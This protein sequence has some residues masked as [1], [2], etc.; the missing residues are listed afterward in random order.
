MLK[1]TL[2][3]GA[4]R[5]S[6]GVFLRTLA[7]ISGVEVLVMGILVTFHDRA[8]NIDAAS[9]I[10]TA[11]VDAGMLSLL[12]A[13]L[14]YA[15]VVR[16][17]AQRLS[18]Q[19][20]LDLVDGLD[21]IVWEADAATWEFSLVSQ[22][23]EEILGYPLKLW[24][25]K[26]DFWGSVI[27][28]EDRERVTAL[29][30][31]AASQGG[32]S[33]LEYRIMTSEGRVLWFRNVV[34]AV[35]DGEGRVRRLRGLMV[36]ITQQKQAEE[37][38]RDTSEKMRTLIEAIPDAVYFKD[39]EGRWLL[40]NSA[41]L[42]AF[43]LEGVS[44]EGK[45]DVEVAEIRPGYRD[46]LLACT[47]TDEQAWKH[48]NASVHEEVI[49]RPDGP[50]VFET[51]KV[52][53]FNHDGSRKGL[54]IVGRDITER[55]L[56]QA[57]LV[58]LADRDPLTGLFNRRRFQ[59]ELEREVAQARRYGSHGAVMF[60]D[61]DDFKDINDSFGHLEGDKL[62]K[63][64]ANLLRKRLRVTDV[65]AR[66]GGD[67][68]A[69][70]LSHTGTRQAQEVADQILEGVGRHTS[71]LGGKSVRITASIGI[72]LYPEHG[73][74]VNELLA[75]ADVAMYRVKED[76]GN[77]AWVYVPDPGTQA[78]TESRL[79]W[80]ARIR[81]AL[82]KDLFVLHAQ[83]IL[84]LRSNRISHHELLLRMV[85]DGGEVIP[86][87]SFLGVAERFGLVHQIDRWVVRRAIGIIADHRRAGQDLCLAV[88]LSGKAFA[89]REL[90]NLIRRQLE[91]NAIDPTRLVLEITE[92]AAV[93]DINQ[94]RQFVDLLRGLGCR[95]ALDDFGVGFSS[96]YN[97]KHL[98]VDYLKIDGSFIRDLPR[99][100]V[101]EHVVKA[102]VEVARGMGKQTVA[103]FVEDEETLRLLR[104]YG[105]DYAQGYHIGRPRALY[106]N[107]SK[108]LVDQEQWNPS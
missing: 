14:L 7:V 102:M 84:D 83:P 104:E 54:V 59:E 73:T 41:G 30:W 67:E 78:Q 35:R 68:F 18:L 62:L 45:S 69:I 57:R 39:G 107:A 33:E 80:K 13:P 64:L 55:K 53:L 105:V 101:D 77:G 46:A 20:A 71:L 29:L 60:L 27:H 11:I 28:P 85:G 37:S 5:T 47:R 94:A 56:V 10:W 6:L 51:I 12:S 26:P 95:F 21:A 31:A 43:E 75:H 48:K 24:L 87:G 65:I 76:G 97:L 92:T 70:L 22:R 103:E 9:D 61:L 89:D 106:G 23:A 19:G 36:D 66:L 82:D 88:N 49:S 32:D 108:I 3:K 34:R 42:R 90:P 58:H 72:A 74:T 40:A 4:D 79:S 93:A 63:G 17:G 44:Y 96:F 15:W 1:R 52:P 16:A 98:P 8:G 25:T 99:D 2:Y 91:E 86:P 81:E 100:A 50:L 38:L